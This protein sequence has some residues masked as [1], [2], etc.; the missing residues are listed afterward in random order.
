MKNRAH[1]LR[2][3]MTPWCPVNPPLQTRFQLRPNPAKCVCGSVDSYPVRSW[4][5][6]Q[7]VTWCI[8][9][10]M[11]YLVLAWIVLLKS[12]ICMMAKYINKSQLKA[13]TQEVQ[14]IVWTCFKMCGAI[15]KYFL[16]GS[17]RSQPKPCNYRGSGGAA[18]CSSAGSEAEV[19]AGGHG[20]VLN[21]GLEFIVHVKPK[22]LIEA[23]IKGVKCPRI[24]GVLF[25]Q[26]AN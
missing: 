8:P 25:E 16:S 22:D 2:K 12:C 6:P 3:P 1:H 17:F 24:E 4:A 23:R 15:F 7:P 26:R 18:I 21:S 9:E 13:V 10:R 5:K 19:H 11:H 14:E 20:T